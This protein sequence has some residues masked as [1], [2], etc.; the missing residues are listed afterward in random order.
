MDS[1][2]YKA[3]NEFGRQVSGVVDAESLE[4][5]NDIIAQLGY[6]PTSVKPKRGGDGAGFGSI[7]KRIGTVKAYELILFTKQLAT[8]IRTGV[9]I[10]R[11]MDILSSQTGNSKLRDTVDRVAADLESGASL[12]AALRHF[13]NIFSPLYTSMVQAGESSGSLPA[14][15]DRLIYVTEHEYKVK[16]DIRS[17]LNY[18]IMVVGALVGA[19]YILLRHVVPKF[20]NV[21]LNANIDLPGPTKI[22]LEL[23]DYMERNGVWILLGTALVILLIGTALRTERGRF[24]RDFAILRIPLVGPVLVKASISRFASIF[25]ILQETGVPVLESMT[26]LGGTI[27]NEAI[28]REVRGV[29]AMLEEGHGIAKPLNESKYFTPMLLNM[30]AIGEETGTLDEMLREVSK[31][32]DAEVE[33]EMKKMSE[34]IGPILIVGLAA[35]V[36]F[37]AL[38]IYM[39]MWDLT[40]LVK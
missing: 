3:I 18:P 8:M 11:S 20:A 15:L 14:V 22:C 4:D 33:Y 32:Y 31:H 29:Q 9:P 1:F 34:A 5:A 40:K 23:S 30:V 7:L 39:P 2:S 16:S 26:I 25:A 19:F 21:F 6:I 17:A 12:S 36:G 13:P 38:A 10:T 37:F 24:M 28:A 27:G 35:V